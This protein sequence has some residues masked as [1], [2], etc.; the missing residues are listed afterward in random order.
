MN[1]RFRSKLLSKNVAAMTLTELLV[2]LVI[3][4]ILVVLALPNQTSVIAKAK[5]T[6]AKLQ[7]EHLHSLQ[8]AYFFEYSKFSNSM[9]ELGFEQ[10][11]T[12]NQ[13]GSANYLIEI[14]SA[15]GNGYLAR[16]TSVVDFD[17][18]GIFNVWEVDQDKQLKESVKD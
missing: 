6:E 12:I 16:A 11:K 4:G 7:L 3:I 8:K 17:Q 1:I 5:A 18:D 14:I 10:Q 15:T 9:E 13:G 2:V